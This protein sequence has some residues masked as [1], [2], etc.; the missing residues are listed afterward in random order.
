MLKP[1]LKLG[2][3][4]LMELSLV[5][6]LSQTGANGHMSLKFNKRTVVEMILRKSKQIK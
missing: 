5:K 3:K 1:H 6:F 2:A 4:G